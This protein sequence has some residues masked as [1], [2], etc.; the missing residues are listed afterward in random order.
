[1]DGESGRVPSPDGPDPFGRAIRDHQRGQREV[2]LYQCDGAAEREHPVQSFYFD[3]RDPDDEWTRWRESWLDGPLLDLG[4]GAGRD[5][6]YF[7]ERTETVA[8][9]VSEHLVATMAARGVEDARLGDMFD[10]RATFDSDRFRSVQAVGTQATLAPSGTALQ[11]LLADL[12]YV[13][14][15]EGTVLLDGY[16]PAA[17]DPG[18]LG[19]RPDPAPGLA[20]R[21]FH[22]EYERERGPTLL[23]R[24]FSPDRLRAA[25]AG[26]AWSVAEVR[27]ATEH[28]LNAALQKR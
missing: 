27:Y 22:F 15:D 4:A 12:A 7:Q 14:D 11:R 9:E 6:L 2:P 26:T 21:A 1:M 25:A 13:T 17:V 19:Y 3:P 18:M 10:L 23:F 16:D 20:R 8:L 5:A 24:L 28:R